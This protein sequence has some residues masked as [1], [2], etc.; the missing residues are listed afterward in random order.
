MWQRGVLFCCLLLDEINLH[1]DTT[2]R[3]LK[4]VVAAKQVH[5]L[6]RVSMDTFVLLLELF[7]VDNVF[8]LQDKMVDENIIKLEV[9]RLRDIL[10]AHTDEVQSLEKRQLQLGT[11]SF[12]HQFHC[13]TMNVST[14]RQWASDPVRFQCTKTCSRLR[15]KHVIQRDKR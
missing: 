8:W 11:V 3:E 4:R 12:V 2:Q 15:W 9:K 7:N 6:H 1:I 14:H 5:N 10:F 13:N